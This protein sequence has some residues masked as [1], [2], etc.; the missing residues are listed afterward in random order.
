[1]FYELRVKED[2]PSIV[3]D[4][5]W[6]PTALLTRYAE[7]LPPSP[8]LRRTCRRAGGLGLRGCWIGAKI[9]L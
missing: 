1:V 6:G 8:R 9:G 4:G 7:E 2:G 3:P 5:R